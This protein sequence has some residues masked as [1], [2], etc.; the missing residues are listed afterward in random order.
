MLSIFWFPKTLDFILYYWCSDE[1]GA[2]LADLQRVLHRVVSS[3][4]ANARQKQAAI[5][6]VCCK[7]SAKVFAHQMPASATC[8][9]LPWCSVRSALQTLIL[10]C[11]TLPA[12]GW[13]LT[14]S[15]AQCIAAALDHRTLCFACLANFCVSD[16]RSQQHFANVL[17]S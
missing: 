6:Q 17:S 13:P 1:E 9:L 10:Y 11:V 15:I 3:K 4:K 12:I 7:A 8:Q 16:V 2:E 5:I 14:C